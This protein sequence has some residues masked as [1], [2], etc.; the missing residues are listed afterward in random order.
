GNFPKRE[1]AIGEIDVV[2]E[3][4]KEVLSFKL[5]HAAIF[6]LLRLI[7]GFHRHNNHRKDNNRKNDQANQHFYQRNAQLMSFP[8][9]NPHHDQFRQLLM[10]SYGVYRQEY[11]FL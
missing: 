11:E 7:D 4:L 6:G 5:E 9:G 3:L 1:K 2:M 10:N 8:E